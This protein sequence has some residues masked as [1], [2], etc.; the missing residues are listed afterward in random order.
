M[1]T[2]TLAKVD[3]MFVYVSVCPCVRACVRP[4][5]RACVRACVH[6]FCVSVC[7]CTALVRTYSFTETGQCRRV[8]HERI[9]H[10]FALRSHVQQNC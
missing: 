9:E 8:E 3:S 6:A 4:C 7:V 2:W 5:V 10:F 1:L